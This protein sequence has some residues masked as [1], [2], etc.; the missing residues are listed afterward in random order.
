MVRCQGCHVWMRMSPDKLLWWGQTVTA[1]GTSI[2]IGGCRAC[3][4]PPREETA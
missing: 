2:Y 4:Y 1:D 3:G